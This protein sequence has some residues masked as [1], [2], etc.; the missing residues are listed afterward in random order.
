MLLSR[1]RPLPRRHY[2]NTPSAPAP[3]FQN[4]DVVDRNQPKT[5]LVLCQHLLY[6]S[7]RY[8]D[9]NIM[10][11]SYPS[12]SEKRSEEIAAGQAKPDGSVDQVDEG[13]K[14]FA[15][16]LWSAAMVVAEGV[17]KRTDPQ[18]QAKQRQKPEKKPRSCGVSRTVLELGA[19]FILYTPTLTHSN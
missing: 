6:S 2:P 10:V 8:G 9:L 18:H 15:H 5:S 13:R 7:L 14:L 3:E 1:L 19:Q 4:Q 17:R 16:F 11:P 12:S